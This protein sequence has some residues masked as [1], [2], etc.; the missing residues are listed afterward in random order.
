MI[1]LIGNEEIRQSKKEGWIHYRHSTHQ[2]K[3]QHILFCVSS[4]LHTQCYQFLL[5]VHFWLALRYSLTFIW[6][7]STL[8]KTEFSYHK[9]ASCDMLSQFH[10]WFLR[11]K[12]ILNFHL[13][14]LLVVAL[15]YLVIHAMFGILLAIWQQFWLEYS[16]MVLYQKYLY[17]VS[18]RNPT[19]QPSQ[20]KVFR[21]DPMGTWLVFLSETRNM[22]ESKL[23]MN[24]HVIMWMVP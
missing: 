21:K 7:P 8:Y 10:I 13:L 4:V 16:F 19:W 23:F 22:I 18:I 5:I 2:W 12:I 20:N 6:S 14:W 15:S 3:V 11:K 1:I 17:P 24:S 9:T